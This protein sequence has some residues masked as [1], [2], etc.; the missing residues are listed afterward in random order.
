M[1]GK[2]LRE[3]LL[4]IS[5]VDGIEIRATI[6]L[7]TNVAWH[8]VYGFADDIMEEYMAEHGCDEAELILTNNSVSASATI[9]D[10]KWMYSRRGVPLMEEGDMCKGYSTRSSEPHGGL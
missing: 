4:A 5:G 6:R 1:N 3:K 9:T 7:R 8:K 2:E 10:G